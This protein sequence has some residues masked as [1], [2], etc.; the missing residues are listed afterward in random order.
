MLLRE[1]VPVYLNSCFCMIFYL[2]FNAYKIYPAEIWKQ[3]STGFCI[4]SFLNNKFK[5]VNKYR[6]VTYRN[7]FITSTPSVN[8]FPRILRYKADHI[9][10]Y[11]VLTSHTSNHTPISNLNSLHT[12][13]VL[14]SQTSIGS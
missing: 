8:A 9:N 1:T 14:F 2:F 3:N 13:Y 12:M 7:K 4:N 10:C 11:F 6:I 5:H